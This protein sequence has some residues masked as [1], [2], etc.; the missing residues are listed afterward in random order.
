[1][2]ETNSRHR[3][4]AASL[5]PLLSLEAL[6]TQY[7]ELL[8]R[9]KL[10]SNITELSN[11][12][13]EID[14]NTQNLDSELNRFVGV[15]SKKHTQELSAVE[16]SRAKLSGAIANSSH[17][18]QIFTSANDLGNSLTSKIK[19]LDQEIGNVD[20][21]LAF[22]TDVQTLKNSVNQIQ[23]AIDKKD[24]EMAAQGIHTIRHKL[25][26]SLVT[27]RFASVVIPS[28]EIPELPTP[29]IEKW[30]AE[31]KEQFQQLFND[32]AKRRSVPEIS[33]YFQLFPL[34]DQE[35]VGLNCYSKFICSIITDTS[36]TLI[37]SVSQGENSGKPGVYASVTTSLFESV[38]M[39][40][41]QH[42]PLINKHYGESYPNAIVYVV[43][44]IQREID[45]QIGLIADTFF[46]ANRIDKVMQD[47][48][49]HSFSE[50]KR[51]LDSEQSETTNI[52]VADND[53]VSIVEV[54]DL[55]HEFSA[56]LRHWSLYCKFLV[57]KYFNNSTKSVE[58][59]EKDSPKDESLKLPSLL[60][61]SHF[62]R[63]IQSK[64]LPAFEA[65]YTFY[66]RRSLEKAISIEEVPPLEP[67]LILSKVS[68][69]PEQAPVSSV[70]ED[71]TLVF[72]NTLR[73]VLD[74]SQPT[75]VK[76]FVTE[77]FKVIQND[78]LNGFI[79]KA[80]TENLPRYNTMLTLRA[81]SSTNGV[82]SGT[83]SPTVSRTGTP[84][85]E[86][87]GGFF[88]G[89]SSALGNVVGQGSAIVS[90]ANTGTVPNNP[91]LIN[92]VIYLNTVASGQEFFE[93][94][95][96]N[97]TKRN[98]HY[99]RNNFPFG[100][101]EEKISHIINAEL[102]E[103][104]VSST[105]SIIKHSLLNLYNVTL[106]NKVTSMVYECFPESSETNYVVYSSSV[107]NDPSTILKFK[108][109]W[110]AIIL[111]FRQTFHKKLIYEK[112]LR[113][114]IVNIASMLEKKLL[115]VL[116]KF[117]V[118]ELGA[119]KLDKDLSYIINEVCEDDYELREKF[120]RVTQLV[121]LVGM[122]NDEYEFSSYKENSSGAAGDDEGGINWVLTPLERK[123]IRRFRI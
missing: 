78:L 79:Q 11:L 19:V 35:E 81:S 61:N 31:L 65:L 48:K 89:A 45:S 9:F 29:T 46:D 113:L 42:T 90:G 53:L 101:D 86:T 3:P 55:I 108:Q 39:M 122:D 66:F 82:L 13:R 71:V 30:I 100:I 36:R 105:S 44:K 63:K 87:V 24:W 109:S 117:K 7:Q 27:G 51:N 4:S 74:S 52:E 37:N 77:C 84:A 93:Q 85:P 116:K 18:T 62:N 88:K 96:N 73:N 57:T 64:Y 111:P 70:I 68:K 99:L 97:L 80:L 114:L 59:A 115:A 102:L 119:L 118:N 49:L 28:S 25:S 72:N 6:D 5:F 47:I 120:V 69:S 98:P 40:L 43:Q 92:F 1:M 83:A 123:Q 58:A 75:T 10:A 94:I 26:P 21:T 107:L 106:K 110:D 95:I 2:V 104:F 16:L 12:V 121:L 54:G 38:S 67:Y 50:L 103:P 22:V 33:K 34:I 41:S 23:Y 91:K 17:L 76:R 56:I 8:E 15:A 112:L 60:A 32:A 14:Q 20:A